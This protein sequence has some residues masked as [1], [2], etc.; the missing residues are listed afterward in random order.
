MH[1]RP[2]LVTG[3]PRSGTSWVG[4]M[5]DASGQVVYIN[6]PLNPRHPP[7]RSPGVLRAR[8]EH[9]FQYI[10]AENEG[11]F[12]EPFRDTIRLRYHAL[13][14][15]RENRTAYDFAR[16]VKYWS[17]FLRG[18]IRGRR[19]LLD[20]PYAVLSVEW[21]ARRLGCQV[22]V[23]VRHPA[24]MASSRKRLGYLIDLDELLQQPL[25]L[26]EWL[27]PFREEMET[28][29]AAGSDV[30][31]QSGL[32]W[33]LI[34]HVV[35]G[36]RDR[37]EDVTVVRHEDLS[38]RPEEEFGRLYE[39]LGLGFSPA[40]RRAVVGSTTGAEGGPSHAWTVSWRGISRTGF[41]PLDSRALVKGW[42]TELEPA[43]IA[44]VRELTRDVAAHYYSDED[45][46]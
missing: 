41:R 1:R 12:L 23:L 15:V 35:A 44:R 30:I 21:F 6:E 16:L 14:E 11:L 4:K 29:R 37:V 28:M 38:L 31:G 7:G 5:L 34:Y 45:W 46:E 8:V 43:E 40:A 42:R 18:R 19:P 22:V 25:L 13:E 39:H 26:E 2:I 27:R 17:S 32:L 33:R 3:M 20:D 9:R 10:S 36:V 24:A